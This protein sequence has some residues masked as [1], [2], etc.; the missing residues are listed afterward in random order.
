MSALAQKFRIAVYDEFLDAFARLPRAQQK[1]VSQFMRKF[2]SDP[3]SSAINYEKISTFRDPNMRTVRIDQQYRAVIL[4]PE[5]GNVYVLLWVDNHDEAMAWAEHKKVVIHPETGSLQVLAAEP[6]ASVPM[7]PAAALVEAT[8]LFGQWSDAELMGLGV[9]EQALPQV[10]AIRAE[11]ELDALAASLPAEAY[12]ALFFLGSGEPLEAVRQALAVEKPPV[13]DTQ[14]FGA[15]LETA[16]SQRRFAVVTDDQE[17]E[18]ILDAPLEKWRVFLHPSQRRIVTANFNG[19]AR[20]LGGAGTG[21]TVVAM[22]RA[23][24]L[25]TQV[26]TGDE[27]RILFTTFTVNL[28]RDIQDSLQKLVPPA[29]MRRIEVVHLDKWTADFL[30]SQGYDYRIEYWDMK[31]S[32][33]PDLWERALTDKP[34]EVGLPRAFFREEWDF[35]VQPAGC[36]SYEEYRDA[37]RVGRGV[38]L[39]RQQR[40][41][42]WP[43]FEEYRNRLEAQRIRE[44]VDAMRDVVELLKK[45]KGRSR[46]R[47]VIVDEA[48]DMATVAFQVLRALVPEEANDLFIVG[49]GHQRIYR[50]KV[51]LAKAGVKIT[52]RSKKLYINYRTTDEI[53]RYAVALLQG[54]SVDDLDDG[55]DTNAKYKSL[56]HGAP[57][58]IERCGGFPKEVQTIAEFVKAAEDP[59][60]TCLVTRTHKDLDLYDAA[61]KE[62]GIPTYRIRRSQ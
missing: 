46:Y 44:P 41:A 58:R 38:R 15:A 8:P 42:I 14:D 59:K 23:K 43:V 31:G 40:K 34:E 17:L 32:P 11:A 29:A 12:E 57:P 54:V 21:K 56:M 26:F 20:V 39:S 4:K 18:A 47:A 61:L 24:H 45:I 51:S 37:P 33:L 50:R 10:R 9:P 53:R 22:H 7:A 6:V 27:D 36:A 13:I 48:Q 5:Q 1:K 30:K 3:T 62:L 60:A 25:V 19:P 16:T 2:R 55:A 52:G 49:D 35:V 28:A